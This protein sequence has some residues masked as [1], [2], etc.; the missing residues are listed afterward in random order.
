MVLRRR[1]R[2]VLIDRSEEIVSVGP[3]GGVVGV[4]IGAQTGAKAY[5]VPAGGCRRVVLQFEDVLVI[6]RHARVAASGGEG[7][8]N[9]YGRSEVGGDLAVAHAAPLEVGFVDHARVDY[10]CVADLDR[11]LLIVY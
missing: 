7:S 10:H 3:G 6:A 9:G 2:E 8:L 5:G 1:L 4:A 11:I